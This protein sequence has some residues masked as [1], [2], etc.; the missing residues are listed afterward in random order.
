MHDPLVGYNWYKFLMLTPSATVTKN[1]RIFLVAAVLSLTIL[2][3][4]WGAPGQHYLIE[5]EDGGDNLEDDTVLPQI[6]AGRMRR[7]G[8]GQAASNSHAGNKNNIMIG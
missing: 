5:T 8:W 1:M 6:G 2:A 4:A 3:Q 7:R